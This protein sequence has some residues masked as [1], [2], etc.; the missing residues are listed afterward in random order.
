MLSSAQNG[1]SC[2]IS[3]VTIARF[4]FV[5]CHFRRTLQETRF[6]FWQSF[7]PGGTELRPVE[8]GK[9]ESL[10]SEQGPDLIGHVQVC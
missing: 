6:M 5:A 8:V 3:S 1:V 4:A 10:P 9:V 2:G 7:S